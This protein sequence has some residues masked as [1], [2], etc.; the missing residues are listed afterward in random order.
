MACDHP[1]DFRHLTEEIRRAA[2][3][4]LQF[5]IGE[6]GRRQLD[7]LGPDEKAV[8]VAALEFWTNNF[9]DVP[10]DAW[11]NRSYEPVER[12]AK[13]IYDEHFSR[14][15]NGKV[16]PWTPHGNS[17]A[18]DNARRLARDELRDL[19]ANAETHRTESAGSTPPAEDGA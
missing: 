12:R 14:D 3:I 16:H 9:S 8:I 18:Q 4:N 17:T 1:V 19:R 5:P 13:E 11:H 6:D 2:R 15:H 7:T 10:W